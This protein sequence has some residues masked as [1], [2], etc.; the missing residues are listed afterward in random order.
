MSA[1]GANVLFVEMSF[2]LQE[3]KYARN[4]LSLKAKK[5]LGI[6]KRRYRSGKMR[7]N[8]MPLPQSKDN[9]SYIFSVLDKSVAVLGNKM[10]T[11]GDDVKDI[12]Q[13]LEAEYATKEWVDAQYGQTKKLVNGITL[14]ILTTVL[15]ALLGLVIAK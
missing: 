9:P 8:T 15:L 7:D 2:G 12:K 1:V 5:R 10:D 3:Q 11:L 4:A 13:K 6:G 14:T